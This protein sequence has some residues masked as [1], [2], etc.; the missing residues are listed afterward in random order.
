MRRGLAG[1]VRG[2][3]HRI[4]ERFWGWRE[5]SR[6]VARWEA[7]REERE[8]ELAK[9]P[10]PWHT[11]DWRVF[12]FIWLNRFLSVN[13]SSIY[14]FCI[15]HF[16]RHS[17]VV[18]PSLDGRTSVIAG[19]GQSLLQ[20]SLT[21][22]ASQ[23]KPKAMKVRRLVAELFYR[24]GIYC[25]SHPRALLLFS[26]I[27]IVGLSSPPI[28]Q[29]YRHYSADGDSYEPSQFW[30]TPA[31][32]LPLQE[33]LFVERFGSHPFLRLEQIVV[34]HSDTLAAYRRGSGPGVLSQAFFQHVLDLQLRIAAAAVEAPLPDD[35]DGE[36][37]DD[38]HADN[39][40]VHDLDDDAANN[41]ADAGD[42]AAENRGAPDASSGSSSLGQ[43]DTPTGRRRR[44]RRTI[45]LQDICYKP[46]SDG[47]C[48]VH[49]PLE[50]WHSSP[51]R[52]REDPDFL[53]TLSNASTLSS[54]G[55]PI[56]LHSVLG[57]VVFDRQ[58]SLVS[59]ADSVVITY[60]LELK[61]G[62]LAE[63]EEWTSLV[64]DRIWAAAVRPEAADGGGGG[65]GGVAPSD[66]FEVGWR[67]EGEVRHL[68]YA[69]DQPDDFMSAEF[70]ILCISYFIVFLYISLVLGRVELVKSK[71]GLGL[72]A[73]VM[74]LSSLLMSVGLSSMMGIT[75]SL[76]PW[77]VL[78][79]LII[80]VGVENIFVLTNAVVT[81]SLDLPV[82]ERVGIGSTL[83]P[84]ICH[85]VRA[86]GT[87]KPNA[88][89]A[90][91]SKVGVKMSLSLAGELFF[92][93]A[94]SMFNLPTLQEF[95]LFASVAVVMD[96]FMQIT[97]FTTVLSIDIRRLELSD[98]HK[99]RHRHELKNRA[100][101]APQMDSSPQKR[102]WT[103]IGA[104][105]LA[106]LAFLG[107]GFYG[108]SS[109]DMF[110]SKSADSNAIPMSVT[111]DV[112]WS[113]I[114]P[115]KS[116]RYVEIL[117]P[118]YVTVV[119]PG[120]P[121]PE[122]VHPKPI[123]GRNWRITFDSFTIEL[124][125]AMFTTIIVVFLLAISMTC[126]SLTSLLYRFSK[127]SSARR[128]EQALQHSLLYADRKPSSGSSWV[129]S[130][131]S[132]MAVKGS[133]HRDIEL[134][135]VSS[136]GVVAWSCAG[137]TA[138]VWNPQTAY[139]IEI[140]PP[141]C[142]LD[143]IT[144][145]TVS[146]GPNSLLVLGTRSGVVQLWDPN[147]R[148]M[149]VEL[150]STL[151]EPLL[152]V[153]AVSITESA[154][155]LVVVATG[156]DGLVASWRTAAPTSQ[157]EH[158]VPE[159]SSQFRVGPHPVSVICDTLPG[160]TLLASGICVY[161]LAT[162]P[163]F[164]ISSP[165]LQG[166]ASEVSA[167]AA[168]PLSSLIATGSTSGEIILWHL[169]TRRE[170]LYISPKLSDPLRS[171][172]E[173]RHQVANATRRGSSSGSKYD[174]P[175]RASFESTTSSHASTASSHTRFHRLASLLEAHAGEVTRLAFLPPPSLS[176]STTHSTA[177]DGRYPNTTAA[178]SFSS[179]VA[180]SSTT[181]NSTTSTPSSPLSTSS[182]SPTLLLVSTGRDCVSKVWEVV[183]RSGEGT[184]PTTAT[185]T[186]AS[187]SA[188]A[189]SAASA[190]AASS[191]A[192]S[193]NEPSVESARLVDTI[194][195]PGAWCTAVHGSWLVGVRRSP[196]AAPS[197]SSSSS[198]P[199]VP[200]RGG[201]GHAPPLLPQPPAM[202]SWS[203]WMA[204]LAGGAAASS[205]GSPG[206]GVGRPLNVCR[207]I[208]IGDDPFHGVDLAA[209][210]LPGRWQRRN[211]PLPSVF[212]PRKHPPPPPSQPATLHARAAL[213]G[214]GGG[215]VDDDDSGWEDEEEAQDDY[216]DDGGVS[217][218]C[219]S[220]ESEEEEEVV[221]GRA[222]SRSRVRRRRRQQQQHRPAPFGVVC[223][224]GN[225]LKIVSFHKY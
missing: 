93:L 121:H 173:S 223:G 218:R 162:A 178:A 183:L 157:D 155:D 159:C 80:A 168:D 132:V 67:S 189:P 149:L 95:C 209:G 102:S 198:S 76:V 12:G 16:S 39:L 60:F 191:S 219:G 107:L 114:N 160:R 208:H 81:T 56:P 118:V 5:N 58:R 146:N 184:S 99:L 164:D 176:S 214:G 86:N 50:Y 33:E 140:R 122:S 91:L 203:V 22:P 62:R 204:S 200:S 2:G 45:R 34:N 215:V 113:V 94:V 207:F 222:G 171:P 181:A 36:D 13:P 115:E 187:A 8:A 188:S 205:G 166:H 165:P 175:N 145:L 18:G 185:A 49:S 54:F 57:G 169:P 147:Q 29:A 148:A 192:G 17:L 193:G 92:M 180:A 44:R 24:H 112:L 172:V 152:S 83:C 79:F 221:V 73:V 84:V 105:V 129:D 212:P 61:R 27:L 100:V 85:C 43:G 48:L 125:P 75:S 130:N 97:F 150:S 119:K 66:A 170:L 1:C 224:F 15:L 182:F 7:E 82:K 26:A 141:L 74:V 197:S 87:D 128:K 131:Y 19:M 123:A 46:F 63:S 38:D 186:P 21:P 110:L 108:S 196:S 51:D 90:G 117:P 206:V 71:F 158:L 216:D 111:A 154:G 126:V 65:G 144:A 167:I 213:G 199:P 78:P 153:H 127:K 37:D 177:S 220:N 52:L 23:S 217:S 161:S 151:D 210:P 201:V 137:R 135:A 156:S 4:S 106:I 6:E 138:C 194:A 103:K 10:G 32:R 190:A 41:G 3:A 174:P 25:A 77:E 133:S 142:K 31:S 47:R 68:Y 211:A 11:V 20:G 88:T 64:W 42:A 96:F 116:D 98:L 104:I 30:D 9:R 35:D 53:R 143:R 70:M 72:A 139:K 195:H 124:S 14:N 163:Q 179:P 28:L 136:Y 120:D 55:T 109:P 89:L 134:M 202:G 69:F 101:T 59:G 225:R 40:R